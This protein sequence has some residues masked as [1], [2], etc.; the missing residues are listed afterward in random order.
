MY[1]KY[2]DLLAKNHKTSYQVAKD[3]GIGQ[4][5]LSDWKAGKIKTLGINKLLTLSKYF[6]VDLKYF[7]SLNEPKED[8]NHEQ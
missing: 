5:T 4:S 2:A 3:T 7:V 1:K 8:E 6:G